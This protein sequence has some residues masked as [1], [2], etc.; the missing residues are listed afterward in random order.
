MDLT[1]LEFCESERQREI[2]RAIADHGSQRKAGKALGVHPRNLERT[3]ARIR[4]QA[5]RRG[6]SPAFDM[7]HPTPPTHV[8]RGVSTYYDKDGKPAAQWVKSDLVAER[9]AEAMR[10]VAE[11]LSASLPRYKPAPLP[12]MGNADLLQLYGITDYHFGMLAWGE[13]TGADWDVDIAERTLLDWFSMAI[14]SS[15]A[16]DTAIFCN[17]GDFLHADGFEALT[18]ASKHLLDVDTR[19]QRVVRIAIRCIRQIIGMLLAK[20]KH[21]HIIMADA[22]HDP[23]SGIWLREWLALVYEF[24]PR[25]TVDNRPDTY[26]H[27]EFGNN[28]LAFH[29]GHK[30]GPKDI[31]PVLTAKFREAYG[32]TQ[33]HYAFTGH[34]HHTLE[35]ET[36]LWLIRQM[37]TLCSPD[38]YASRSGYMSGRDA[39]AM[40]FHRE[41]GKIG[42]ITISPAMLETKQ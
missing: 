7:I 17:L 4:L 41:Y 36:A 42:A 8:A 6:Y 32:R 39:E 25:V 26:Y 30:R 1:Y 19:F 34:L 20:H 22:N 3:V 10:A 38:A 35:H 40:T 24:E 28:L 13:E 11:E 27:Y 29:H 21:V 9:Q 15:P 37:R 5:A 12:T 2:V 33:H 18:P 31:G 14:K 23:A 16:A